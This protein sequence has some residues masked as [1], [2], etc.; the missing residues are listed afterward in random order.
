MPER[1]KKRRDF[2]AAARASK[3]GRGGFTL[4]MRKRGDADSSPARVGFTV[5]KRIA[6]KAVERNR[7]R[8]R[9]KELARLSEAGLRPGHDYVLVARRSAL[10]SDFAELG[11]MLASA[12]RQAHR[13]RAPAHENREQSSP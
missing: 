13:D 4:E 12:L 9:L 6:A 8:R 7:I 1:L 10:T 2:L 5:S 11:D 3:I